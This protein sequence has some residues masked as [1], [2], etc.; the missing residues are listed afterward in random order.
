MSTKSDNPLALLRK[1]EDL[2]LQE[3]RGSERPAL[4]T[5]ASLRG[6]LERSG[7][8][9]EPHEDSSKSY[10]QKRAKSLRK[11]SVKLR[12]TLRK[13]STADTSYADKAETLSVVA[14]SYLQLAHAFKVDS[15]VWTFAQ[16][17]LV[18]V[19]SAAEDENSLDEAIS[20]LLC[21]LDRYLSS[22]E[23]WLKK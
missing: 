3:G 14:N 6:A 5:I 4:G 7:Y 17:D 18:P 20:R 9:E 11:L 13:V 8:R 23:K 15:K 21:H 2:L 16:N 19:L 12:D 22:L 1:L 10:T